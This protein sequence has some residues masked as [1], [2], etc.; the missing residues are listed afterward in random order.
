MCLH[1]PGS[2]VFQDVSLPVRSSIEKSNR[3]RLLWNQAA[4]LP[5][6][7][8]TCT[9]SVAPRAAWLVYKLPSFTK[10]FANATNYFAGG[11]Y[12]LYDNTN[13]RSA[14][15]YPRNISDDFRAIPGMQ[16]PNIPSYIDSAFF[17]KRDGN[18]YFFKGNLVNTIS[19]YKQVP[20]ASSSR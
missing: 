4:S 18:L 15:G 7:A 5:R 20:S 2:C 13:D 8:L 1:F 12:Y 6:V 11:H 17:D 16:F 14:P 3:V 9:I 10:V 19:F